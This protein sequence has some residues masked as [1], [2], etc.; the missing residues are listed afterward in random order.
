M[1]LTFE[2]DGHLRA[3]LLLKDS[4]SNLFLQSQLGAAYWVGNI[5]TLKKER[6]K[7]LCQQVS[8]FIAD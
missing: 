7:S 5:N 3:Q 2:M 8:S 6:K 1:A 4:F